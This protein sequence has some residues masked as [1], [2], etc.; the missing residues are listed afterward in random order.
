MNLISAMLIQ[1]KMQY[2]N[3]KSNQFLHVMIVVPY[4]YASH[5]F[6]LGKSNRIG[7]KPEA[8]KVIYSN[9]VLF[10]RI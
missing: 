3:L 2:I 1:I 10:I 4:E 7:I 9:N 8:R 5:D 6:Q